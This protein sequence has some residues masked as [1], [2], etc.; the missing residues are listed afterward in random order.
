MGV[1][2]TGAETVPNPK[3]PKPE[4][5][6]LAGLSTRASARCPWRT[7]ARFGGQSAGS[8]VR[9]FIVPGASPV[10]GAG[11]VGGALSAGP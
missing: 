6:K 4:N 2:L 10:R 8:R 11:P 9:G 5:F 1:E 3:T 7:T